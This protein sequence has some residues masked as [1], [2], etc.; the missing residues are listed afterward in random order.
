VVIRTPCRSQPVS[1][2]RHQRLF[3]VI[4]LAAQGLFI[5]VT[6][7]AAAAL[8]VVVIGATA[9]QDRAQCVDDLVCLPHL[10]PAILAMLA[11][12]VVMAVAGPLVALL[13]R[14][15]SPGLFATP[16]LWTVVAAD[17]QDHW[18]FNSL[19]STILILL[20]SYALLAVWP[21]GEQ[22]GGKKDSDQA[23]STS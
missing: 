15:S 1:R 18:P 10:G 4:V 23:E 17:L 16:V 9:R 12:P 20:V 7:L 21:G 2:T 14:L 13:L 6:S 5:G 8:T 22:Q 3:K 11:M 19:T